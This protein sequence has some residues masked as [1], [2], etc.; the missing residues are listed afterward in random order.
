[1]QAEVTDTGIKLTWEQDDFE[2]LAGYNV[3]RSTEEDGMYTR[4]N[5]TVIPADT[6]EWFDDEVMPGQRYYYNFT[7][8]ESDMA[9]SEPSGKVQVTAMDTM[10]PNIYHTP[11]YHAFTGSNLVIT[12]EVTDNVAISSATLYYRTTGTDSWKS[13]TMTNFNDK[14]SAIIPSA[15]ITVDGLEYYI[16][17]TD[18]NSYTYKGSA[19]NPYSI[20]VQLAVSDSEKGD[21]DGNGTIELRD[22]LMVLMAINDRLNLTEEQFVRANLNN[23]EELSAD[24]ALRILQYA[25]GMISSVLP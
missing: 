19:E 25:N 1:M 4:L 14:Y 12:A 13:I 7:V 17:A 9:E 11:V 18:G 24:E 6:K 16:E 20:T 10:A 8:V 22:A 23:D 2:T 3:Y 5:K 15:A 21:V